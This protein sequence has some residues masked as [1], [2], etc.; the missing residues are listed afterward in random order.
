MHVQNG[1]RLGPYEIV[2]RLGAGGMGEVWKARDTRLDRSVAVKIL[3]AEYA[4]DEQL[5]VRFEREAKTISQLSHPNICTLFDVGDGYLVM[6]LLEG[7]SLADRLARGALPLAEVFRFGA[8][9]AEALDRAH[10]AGVVHRDLKPANIML[11]K[12]GAKLLDFGMAK[13]VVIDVGGDGATMQR[14]LTQ[15]GTILGTFQY[16]APEQLEAEEADAR[17]DIFAFGAVLYEMAT[18]HLAFEGKTRTS[19]IAAIVKEQPRPVS[20]WQPL[21]PPALEHIIAKCLEKDPNDRWQSA[22]DIAEELR[23]AGNAGSQ[24]GIPAPVARR[25]GWRRTF[26]TAACSIAAGL[27]IG[28]AALYSWEQSRRIPLRMAITTPDTVRIVTA[29]AGGGAVV[30]PDGRSVALVGLDASATRRLYLRRFDEFDFRPLAL[31]EGAT[32]PFWS[33]DGKSIAFFADGKLKR[34]DL[35][36]SPPVVL[37]DAPD[38]RGGAWSKNGTILYAPVYT[39]ALMALQASG[40]KTKAPPQLAPGSRNDRFPS[41]FPDGDHY[42]FFRQGV[43][44]VQGIWIGSLESGKIARIVESRNAAVVSG[45][46]AILYSRDGVLLE[47]HVDLEAMTIR[48]GERPIAQ[49]VRSGGDRNIQILSTAAGV[50]LFQ[51]GATDQMAFRWFDRKGMRGNVVGPPDDYAEPTFA[52]HESKV[53]ARTDSS[54]VLREVDLAT[55]RATRLTSLR[56][57]YNCALAPADGSRVFASAT[58]EG[59]QSLVEILP[60]TQ[61]RIIGQ[62]QKA[63]YPDSTDATGDLLLIEGQPEN[64]R[65]DFDLFVARRGNGFKLEPLLHSPANES[66]GQLSL[67]GKFVAYSSDESGR[68]EVYVQPVPPTGERWVVSNNGGDQARWRGDAGELFYLAPDGKIMS[69][70]IRSV[71]PFQTAEPEALFTTQISLGSV[72]ADRNQYLVTPDGQRFLVLEPVPSTRG[73]ELSVIT[74]WK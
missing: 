14:P 16:M 54:D 45:D 46:D 1:S 21:T 35:H 70:A 17:T 39:S 33:P 48:G 22:H 49:N 51:T 26:I 18:G 58:T 28:A 37:A 34:I 23:W 9:I 6:E 60:G 55:G 2:S 24:A 56:E 11:T 67:D 5:K 40:A 68:G 47:Q 74:N 12:S 4:Q 8:Q 53:I 57:N 66:H 50:V 19:L 41:F 63:K 59:K 7:D 29:N 43:P 15:E 62:F 52:A 32:Y 25:R 10:R 3:P 65:N 31:S 64:E 30:A 20:H 69:V 42:V 44:S 36:G 27:A 13:G 73:N 71:A 61:R 72:L 38:G